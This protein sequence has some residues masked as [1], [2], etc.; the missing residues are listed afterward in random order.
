MANVCAMI[1]GAR[2]VEA[3]TSEPIRTR[4]VCRVSAAMDV[5]GSTAPER[6]PSGP[7]AKGWSDNHTESRPSRSAATAVSSVP[8]HGFPEP[9]SIRY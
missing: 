9:T 6:T 4:A 5:S 1:A 8:R 7:T 2:I 3:S